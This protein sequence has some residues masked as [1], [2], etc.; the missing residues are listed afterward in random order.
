MSIS[1]KVIRKLINIFSIIV[2]FLTIIIAVIIAHISFKA[3]ELLLIF[4]SVLPLLIIYCS[5]SFI[6]YSIR[7]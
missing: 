7:N 3:N 1:K 5:N 2:P 6:I 4:Y